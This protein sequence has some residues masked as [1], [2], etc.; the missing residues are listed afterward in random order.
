MHV[1]TPNTV[2]AFYSPHLRLIGKFSG[3]SQ[4]RKTEILTAMVHA[5]YPGFSRGSILAHRI[6]NAAIYQGIPAKRNPMINLKKTKG[7][8]SLQ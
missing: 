5:I 3:T 8:L 2:F 1:K 4:R 6:M 7:Y